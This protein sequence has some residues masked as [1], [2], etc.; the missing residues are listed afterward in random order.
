MFGNNK[1]TDFSHLAKLHVVK[2]HAKV[3][4]INN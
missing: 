3:R 1:D 4:E 2:P